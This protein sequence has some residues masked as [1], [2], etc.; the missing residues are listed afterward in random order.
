[1]TFTKRFRISDSSSLSALM[2][3]APR[4]AAH[5]SRRGWA[6]QSRL[7]DIEERIAF[8]SVSVF[9]FKDR[10]VMFHV[11]SGIRFFFAKK[12]DL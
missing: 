1:M 12:Y 6:F 7:E 2:R 9:L 4:A 10:Y 11:F 8:S 3:A 5:R